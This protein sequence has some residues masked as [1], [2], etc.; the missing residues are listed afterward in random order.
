M[1]LYV[2]DRLI[3]Q[4]YRAPYAF[5]WNTRTLTAGS[6]HKL[7]VTA[8]DRSGRL[9]GQATQHVVVA[10]SSS[11]VVSRI[12]GVLSTAA[13]QDVSSEAACS[14]AVSIL[15]ES[16]VIDGY[17][18][19]T[20]GAGNA[21]TRSQYAK[22]VASALGL[23]DEDVSTTPFS[24][25]GAPDGDLYPQKFVAALRSVGAISGLAPG[26]FAPWDSVSRAQMVTILV[27][28]IQ[29]LD[30]RTL[31]VTG[32]AQPVVGNIGIQHTHSMAIA[33]ANGL[34][35]GVPGYGPGWNPWLPATR[36]E[37]ARVLSNLLN[38]N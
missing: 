20:F 9:I 13:F 26:R 7:A 33:E 12:P 29:T 22:M 25:L 1:R 10:G 35:A 3:S 37:V 14:D 6:T 4:D 24:D 30:A 36:G 11:T 18:N 8:Y 17:T 38:L 2:D 34:L 21:T 5:I 28:S 16:G 32:N 23:A 15:T 31:S 27:R 19:E